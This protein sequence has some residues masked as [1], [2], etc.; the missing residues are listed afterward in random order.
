MVQEIQ[1]LTIKHLKEAKPDKLEKLCE[2]II[3]G[4]KIYK[5]HNDREFLVKARDLFAQHNMM[6]EAAKLTREIGVS[7]Y[8]KGQIK[9][10][11]N[12]IEI[13]VDMLKK[14]PSGDNRD[15][16]L[17]KYML[18]I[19]IGNYERLNYSKSFVAF[20]ECR[21]MLSDKLPVEYLFNYYHEYAI[22]S[23]YIE[24]HSKGLDLL[25]KA[26]DYTGDSKINEGKIYNNLG[27]C[28][29]KMKQYNKSINMYNK[30]IKLYKGNNNK[31][32]IIY[33]NMSLVYND[34]NNHNKAMQ[35]INKCLEIFDKSN[36]KKHLIYY[37][38]YVR[39]AI[40]SE[41]LDELINKL[42]NVI[43]ISKDVSFNKKYIIDPIQII[44]K[45]LNET[46]N[47]EQGMKLRNI[48]ISLIEELG[49]VEYRDYYENQLYACLGE[50][51]YL[52][53]KKNKI[54]G[55]L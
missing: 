29:W 17:F 9:E 27:R 12:N 51:S 45:K 16:L 43:E 53:G 6:L 36:P 19:G 8:K 46:K 28:Y 4:L 18:N 15:K 37:D 32:A 26:L 20:E 31:L 2:I 42:L 5:Y 22:L 11:V 7:Y 47:K 48:I 30:A 23:I 33:N 21:Q 39:I 38:T 1:R 25:N 34:L 55:G 14:I 24:Q 35:L 13:A 40:K 54:R 44:T 3:D 50:L 52:L 49:E 41:Q 10:C